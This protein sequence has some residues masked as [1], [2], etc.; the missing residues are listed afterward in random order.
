[1]GVLPAYYLQRLGECLSHRPFQTLRGAPLAS[2]RLRWMH[3]TALGTGQSQSFWEELTTRPGCASAARAPSASSGNGTTAPSAS[4]RLSLTTG[5]L[6]VLRPPQRTPWVCR[7]IRTYINISMS[8]A[9]IVGSTTLWSLLINLM[10]NIVINNMIIIMLT[11][12]INLMINIVINMLINDGQRV[13]WC[14]VVNT[15]V[16]KTFNIFH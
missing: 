1:M 14:M 13:G 4:I 16:H 10:I 9:I 7:C 15:P 3:T 12:L 11:L 6:K 5:S 8:N 2:C